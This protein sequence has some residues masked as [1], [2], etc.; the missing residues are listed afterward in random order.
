MRT[1]RARHLQGFISLL[2]LLATG[3]FAQGDRATI[4]GTVK[5]STQAIVPGARV[6][7]RTV[8]TNITTTSESNAAG[9]MFSPR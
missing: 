3:A 7:L 6:T 1:H 8:A 9:F 2:L 4:T 5:D